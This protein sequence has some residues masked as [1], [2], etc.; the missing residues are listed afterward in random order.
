MKIT[1]STKLKDVSSFI[2][3]EHI[4]AISEKV[5]NDYLGKYE[6]ILSGTIGD[7]IRL[8]LG[9][10]EFFKEYFFNENADI[11]VY[12][13]AAKLKH[14]KLEIG[15]IIEYLNSL[16]I[17]QSKEEIQA[18]K[19]VSF[20]SF[21]ENILIYCQRKFYLKSFKE[22]ESVLLSDFILHKKSD[23]ANAKYERNIRMIYDI[24]NKPKGKR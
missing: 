13:Y 1:K 4:N 22:T 23:L 24:K 21:A 2:T 19:G 20:P 5:P 8:T 7:F 6:S 18:S 12:E 17:E 16:S 14:L 15:K 9:D 3:N 10:E 11:T